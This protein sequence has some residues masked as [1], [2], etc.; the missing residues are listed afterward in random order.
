MWSVCRYNSVSLRK[1]EKRKKKTE[2]LIT[3]NS[4]CRCKTRQAITCAWYRFAPSPSRSNETDENVMQI[5]VLKFGVNTLRICSTRPR[6][7]TDTPSNLSLIFKQETY[8]NPSGCQLA[9]YKPCS[10]RY[11][12]NTN[13]LRIWFSPS[14]QL[15]QKI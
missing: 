6:I 9:N 3:R 8:G 12:A 14:R 7:T 15:V 11:W 5:R 1:K 4:Y 2:N 10:P 13:A